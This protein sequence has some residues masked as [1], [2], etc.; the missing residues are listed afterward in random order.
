MSKKILKPRDGARRPHPVTVFDESRKRALAQPETF[1]LCPLGC[2]F[3]S[4]RKMAT[5]DLLEFSIDL[6]AGRG[7]TRKQTCTGAVVRCQKEAKSLYRIWLH[8]VDL[9]EAS[10]EHIRCAAKKG[11]H[12]CSYCENF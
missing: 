6:P 3:Y 12:L 2:Q 10:R 8:F 9:P 7:R 5:F 4:Q 1:Q 11:K